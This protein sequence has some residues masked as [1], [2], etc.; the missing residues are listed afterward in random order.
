MERL[1]EHGMTK[2]ELRMAGS[3]IGQRGKA[4]EQ[5]VS[6]GLKVIDAPGRV[7]M[8]GNQIQGVVEVFDECGPVGCVERAVGHSEAEMD[9]CHRVSCICGVVQ[10]SRYPLR[11]TL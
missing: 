7:E 8:P 6:V 3:H 2:H 4:F 9:A 10:R 11:S 1:A 5:I